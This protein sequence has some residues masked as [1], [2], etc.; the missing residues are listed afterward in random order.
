MELQQNEKE[1]TCNF[2]VQLKKR[3]LI[4]IK[5]AQIVKSYEENYSKQANEWKW[6]KCVKT[7]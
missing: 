6:V 1:E 2:T 3:Q 7:L 5:R 4:V